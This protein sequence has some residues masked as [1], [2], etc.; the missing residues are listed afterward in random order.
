[1]P[2]SC[3]IQF[4]AL[5]ALISSARGAFLKL[6]HDIIS[7]MNIYIK[8]LR[9][10]WD[11]AYFADFHSPLTPSGRDIRTALIYDQPLERGGRLQ[12]LIG[13]TTEPGHLRGAASQ[14]YLQFGLHLPLGL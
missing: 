8:K 10:I 12:F 11:T 6:L 3:S 1:M 7:C 9:R 5:A 13:N 14:P 4:F 2:G